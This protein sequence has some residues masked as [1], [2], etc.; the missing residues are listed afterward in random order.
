M[1]S[2]ELIHQG[3]PQERPQGEGCWLSSP[4][5]HVTRSMERCP[6]RLPAS[7]PTPLRG[8]AEEDKTCKIGVVG[9]EQGGAKHV[10]SK[11]DSF[12]RF[13]GGGG[14]TWTEVKQNSGKK[15]VI[16]RAFIPP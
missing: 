8:W 4:S 6:C 12:L 10:V 5:P 11:D 3:D 9:G 15:W 13:C 14:E 2:R 7:S 1:P 16:Q